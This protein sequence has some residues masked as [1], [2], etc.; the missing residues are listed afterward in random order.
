MLACGCIHLLD[1]IL[2]KGSVSG[3][4]ERAQWVKIFVTKSVSLSLI[5]KTHMVDKREST[6]T[7]C[8]LNSTCA[9]QHVCIHTHK[10]IDRQIS[11]VIIKNVKAKK[12]SCLKM[13]HS[14]RKWKWKKK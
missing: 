6:S 12:D 3:A 1:L 13:T 8:P 11:D 2:S 5:P 4:H 7:S 10:E 9:P 14:C